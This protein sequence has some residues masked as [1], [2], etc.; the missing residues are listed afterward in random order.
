MGLSAL[1]VGF[2]GFGEKVSEEIQTQA[3]TVV[4]QTEKPSRSESGSPEEILMKK[5]Y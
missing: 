3:A 1:L 4:L 5:L 2:I